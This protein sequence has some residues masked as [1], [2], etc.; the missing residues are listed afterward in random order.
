MLLRPGNPRVLAD[1]ELRLERLTVEAEARAVR[2]GCDLRADELVLERLP[3][4]A[5]TF[6]L[7]RVGI[8]HVP[9]DAVEAR[10]DLPLWLLR[11]RRLARAPGGGLLGA[12]VPSS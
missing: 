1:L 8:A 9:D 12:L 11:L 5:F 2:A 10:L 6:D 7:R 3:R 4:A